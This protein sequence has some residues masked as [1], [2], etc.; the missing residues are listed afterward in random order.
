MRYHFLQECVEKEEIVV[1]Y[2]AMENQPADLLT[3]AL[4][5]THI[6][7]LRSKVGV[8]QP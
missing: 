4:G 6:Q 7:D 8:Q 5:R 1:S 2:M 3:K